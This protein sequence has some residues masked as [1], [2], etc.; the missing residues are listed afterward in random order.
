[1]C[2]KRKKNLIYVIHLTI[3]RNDERKLK[4]KLIIELVEMTESHH[5]FQGH[6]SNEVIIL[7]H[8]VVLRRPQKR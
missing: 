2:R 8:P 4:E 3:E 5:W 7:N 1:M 6:V